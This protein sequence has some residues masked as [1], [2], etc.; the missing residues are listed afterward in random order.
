MKKVLTTIV[1][2]SFLTVFLLPAAALAQAPEGCKIK[3]LERVTVGT[4]LAC[5]ADC[6]YTNPDCGFCCLLNTLYNITDW[7]FLILVALAGLFVVMGAM[8]LLTAAGD[9][10]KVVSGRNYILYAMVGLLVAFL[11][12]AVPGL[13]RL[14]G[15]F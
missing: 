12:K 11:A 14:I 15:G 3:K 6:K 1:L 8:V 4:D 5:V 10:T 13:V 2:L 7:I 9:P